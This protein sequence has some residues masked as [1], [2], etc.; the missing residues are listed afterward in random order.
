MLLVMLVAVGC[1]LRWGRRGGI[2]SYLFSFC[3]PP[4]LLCGGAWRTCSLCSMMFMMGNTQE[5]DL[6]SLR[7]ARFVDSPSPLYVCAVV[8]RVLR[9]WRWGKDS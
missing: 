7:G 2:L 5:A 3:W 8:F 6:V 9:E 4:Y 1:M